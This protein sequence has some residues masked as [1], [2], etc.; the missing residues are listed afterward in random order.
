MKKKQSNNYKKHLPQAHPISFFLVAT[1]LIA[2]HS[3]SFAADSFTTEFTAKTSV[4]IEMRVEQLTGNDVLSLPEIDSTNFDQAGI[5]EAGASTWNV[6]TSDNSNGRSYMMQVTY[7]SGEGNFA[8]MTN[9]NLSS[10]PNNCIHY[11]LFFRG[12]L[13]HLGNGASP[14]P[15]EPNSSLFWG[16]SFLNN[17]L[18]QGFPVQNQ[19]DEGD[20]AEFAVYRP[21]LTAQPAAGD[22]EGKI[23]ITIKPCGIEDN[24]YDHNLSNP[25]SIT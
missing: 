25:H 10:G 23:T 17:G 13:A 19:C 5:T 11:R 20:F 21:P 22:Y 4:P 8:C 6:T 1:C 9:P 12:C 3:S 2:P 24:C 16:W 7:S 15:Y 14:D 18:W